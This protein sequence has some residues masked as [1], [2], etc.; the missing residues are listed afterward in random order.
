M[1]TPKNYDSAVRAYENYQKQGFP[2]PDT[3]GTT[4]NEAQRGTFGSCSNNADN[5][6][7]TSNGVHDSAFSVNSSL[8]IDSRSIASRMDLTALPNITRN[9]E[10]TEVKQEPG[11]S[12]PPDA[13]PSPPQ[14]DQT[15]VQK[16]PENGKIAGEKE[17]EEFWTLGV[18]EMKKGREIV[19]TRAKIEK[20]QNQIFEA[21]S[22]LQQME[23]EMNEILRRKA[24]L[25]G[26]PVPGT[27]V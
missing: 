7:D 16:D 18:A 2:I 21:T 6:A 8:A 13:L 19:E 12:P 23:V 27:F 15:V 14:F 26:L 9:S 11:E 10:S 3:L 1:S 4:F 20:L 25:L 5:S 17:R 24:E 22:A